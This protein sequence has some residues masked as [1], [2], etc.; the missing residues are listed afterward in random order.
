[1]K[2]ARPGEVHQDLHYPVE[3]VNFAVDDVH[4]AVRIRINLLELVS[5]QL[6]VK[7]DCVNRVLHFMG[8]ATS[9]SAAGGNPAREFDLIFNTA[10]RFSVAHGQERADLSALLL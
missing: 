5:Q 8:N 6:Q 2:V 9:Y 4:V 3:T 1:M 10:G 7:N